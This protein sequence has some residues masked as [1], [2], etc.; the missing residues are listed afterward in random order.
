MKII[1]THNL[2]SMMQKLSKK[3]VPWIIISFIL[4]PKNI[5]TSRQ[6]NELVT[7][8]SHLFWLVL[9]DNDFPQASNG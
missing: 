9:V 7:I 3:K 2:I 4:M 6:L 8:S 1:S 5:G